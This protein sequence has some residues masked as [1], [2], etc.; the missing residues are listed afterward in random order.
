VIV[1]TLIVLQ[2]VSPNSKLYLV[3]APTTT[4]AHAFSTG[5]IRINH[6]TLEWDIAILSAM[7]FVATISVR[8]STVLM[9]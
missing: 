9:L 3:H 2:L 6:A 8:L 5:K 7:M 1:V 4:F